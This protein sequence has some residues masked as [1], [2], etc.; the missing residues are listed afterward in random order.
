M[1]KVFI[2]L[3]TI[4]ALCFMN[5]SMALSS[6]SVIISGSST[7]SLSKKI[8]TELGINL[9]NIEIGKFNDGEIK[10]KIK[11][12]V[13]NKDV[14]II[15]TTSAT[16]NKSVNDNLMEL[17]LLARTLKRASAKSITA[18]VPYFSYA[19]QD[20]KVEPRVPIS[21]SDVAMLI[22]SSGV[23]RVVSIDLH[24]GQIQGFFRDVPLDNLYGST[25]M[26]PYF[27]SLGLKDPVII[28]PDA[29][30]VSR[31]KSFRDL[32]AKQGINSDFAIIVK[33]RS[34]AGEIATANLI[35]NVSGKDAII[36][37]DLCDTGGTLV[38]SAEELKKFGAN[39]IYAAITHPVFSKDAIKKIENSEFTQVVVTDT[40]PM[41]SL[42]LK[43]IRQ[44]SIAPLIAAVINKIDN[45]ESISAVFDG[46]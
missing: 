10:I 19:R 2:F 42:N 35:G 16:D 13:R 46:V 30:G 39:N 36:V 6:S 28:S 14:F 24:S 34:G 20:R 44:I 32:L 40:I 41:K 1:K 15:Q 23:N 45:S 17:Y 9:I 26:V 22:E 12:S 27:K 5:V 43:K 7:Q 29:G 18:I 25:L 33:Q 37:D 38:K 11:E 3:L 21:A 31:A 4:I 8:A